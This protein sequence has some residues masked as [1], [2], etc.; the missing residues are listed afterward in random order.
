[1][2]TDIS[3]PLK[4]RFSRADC[5]DRVFQRSEYKFK[6]PYHGTAP[7]FPFTN[8]QNFK[9]ELPKHVTA[10]DFPFMLKLPRQSLP[11]HHSAHRQV[12]LQLLHSGQ[13]C[14]P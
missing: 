2:P 6:L 7:N 10:P 1:M 12:N 11:Y 8:S 13:I 14:R 9:F 3:S 5:Y 4:T